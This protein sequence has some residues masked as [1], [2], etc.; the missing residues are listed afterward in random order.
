MKKIKLFGYM[1]LLS[2]FFVAGCSNQAT[3]KEASTSNHTTNSNI[4]ESSSTTTELA[5]E[6]NEADEEIIETI[7]KVYSSWDSI[8]K[9]INENNQIWQLQR[10]VLLEN[11]SIQA[12]F[13][14]KNPIEIFN[15]KLTKSYSNWNDVK[16]EITINGK[17]WRLV[18]ARLVADKVEADYTEK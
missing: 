8:P 9:E 6:I 15:G 4:L 16:K 7:D 13:F 1:V 14:K 5:K 18:S 3:K 17:N 2:L 11:N 10:A 12:T